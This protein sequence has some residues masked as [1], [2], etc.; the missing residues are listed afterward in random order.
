MPRTG[1]HALGRK[2]GY[3]QLPI[4]KRHLQ[5]G[6]QFFGYRPRLPT[7]PPRREEFKM[8]TNPFRHPAI[9][10]VAEVSL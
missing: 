5:F 3:Q 1:C 7:E 10:N 4:D 2:A 9:G 8:H 6:Y